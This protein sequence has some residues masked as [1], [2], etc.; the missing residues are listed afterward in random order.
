MRNRSAIMTRGF[1]VNGPN[2]RSRRAAA[3]NRGRASGS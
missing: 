2:A 3:A 1:W